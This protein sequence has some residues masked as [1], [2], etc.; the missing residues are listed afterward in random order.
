MY[1]K[2][3][4]KM[5]YYNINILKNRKIENKILYIYNIQKTY[6]YI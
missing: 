4:S 3:A 5:T 1:D 2:K 6:V